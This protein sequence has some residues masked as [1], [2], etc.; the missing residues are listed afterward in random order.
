MPPHRKWTRRAILAATAAC[1]VTDTS[2]AS[3][4]TVAR[5]QYG[6]VRGWRRDGVLCFLGVRYGRDTRLARFQ[7]P[8][9]P[10]PWRGVREARAYGPASPQ[11]GG[12]DTNQSED[13]LFLNVWTPALDAG[14]RTVMVYIHGGAYSS[15]SAAGPLLDG[16]RLCRRG[17][18]VVVTLNH[19]LGPFGY[20]YLARLGDERFADSGNAGQ[21]D[22]ILA[23]EWVRDNIGNFGGDP[24]SVMVFGQSG[25]GAKI[26]TLMAM[27]RANGLFH[28][29]ATMSGQQITAS[30]PLNA[31][32]RAQAL[33]RQME[34]TSADMSRLLVVP[35][36]LLLEAS[37][38]TDPV[39]DYGS[40][41]FGPV[42]DG[43]NL[44]RHPFYP[45]A[46]PQSL[47][48]PMMLGNTHDETRGF[49]GADRSLFD[50]R[51]EDLPGRLADAMRVDISPELVV[52]RYRELYP[53]STPS[54]VYFAATT[55]S[56]SWRGQIIEA[57]ERAKA[58][59][60]AYVYQL[61]WRAPAEGGLF[62]APHT[63][64]IPL[65]FGNLEASPYIGQRTG[66]AE[67]V[68][69]KMMDAFIAFAKTG[70][71]NGGVLPPWPRYALPARDTM[72]FDVA[73]RVERDP[74][75][76]ERELFAV[77]PYVQPGT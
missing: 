33:L 71:P 60:P 17:D 29:A 77:A 76:A 26:A 40:L 24:G 41:Y 58:G 16:A 30:G 14:R 49:V 61:D 5:T 44:L 34:L 28:R 43:R 46:A 66:E 48:I 15:G 70:D 42:L 2:A 69:A 27:P 8:K 22:L 73:P 68:S 59:A 6:R 13:C 18:V 52:R 74:R 75:K 3:R 4:D 21:L 35:P 7:A 54:E 51:W 63:L 11:R 19:R 32:R 12:G 64:D 72:I 53:T 20:A 37:A 31:T 67:L 36:A 45:D 39:L 1:F 9:P 62:G 47:G 10:E 25:G 65:V 56:R 23:L 50:L 38:I 55:A 57:E